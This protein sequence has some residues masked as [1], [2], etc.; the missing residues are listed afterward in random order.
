MQAIYRIFA[1]VLPTIPLSHV[2]HLFGKFV[3]LPVTLLEND[4]CELLHTLTRVALSHHDHD[5]E[6][7]NSGS[8]IDGATAATAAA[9]SAVA[10]NLPNQLQRTSYGL[11][12]FWQ[13]L[14]DGSGAADDLVL[15]AMRHLYEL[16]QH[17][18]CTS[19]RYVATIPTHT[20]SVSHSSASSHAIVVVDRSLDPQ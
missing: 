12:I 19:L 15:E 7:A 8:S 20:R 3:A 10:T 1:D 11:A 14:Q 4:A 6:L 17:Q 18:I 9:T 2:D 5:H 16:F 13:I